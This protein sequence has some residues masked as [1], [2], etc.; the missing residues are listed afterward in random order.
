MKLLLLLLLASCQ[1]YPAKA[2]V[3]K[4]LDVKVDGLPYVGVGVLQ[5]Q[6]SYYIEA[7]SRHHPEEIN[8]TT[9][10]RAEPPFYLGMFKKTLRW[11]YTPNLAED[12]DCML[13]IAFLDNKGNS[14]FAA[15][16]IANP[17]DTLPARTDCNGK[18]DDSD[19]TSFC[20]SMV[21][22]NQ[23]ITFQA[24][25][26]PSSDCSL[27]VDEGDKLGWRYQAKEGICTYIFKTRDGQTHRLVNFG[28]TSFPNP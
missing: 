7:H 4:D 6:E 21:G 18:V 9:C 28:Y 23:L 10:N 12:S 27:P 14:Q 19:G 3:Y 1:S 20:Q 17:M 24:P 15:L 16:V 11:T 13:K 25:A 2:D 22:T 5:V 8:V 26:L